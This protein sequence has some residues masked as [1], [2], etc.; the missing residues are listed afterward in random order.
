MCSSWRGQASSPGSFSDVAGLLVAPLLLALVLALM[1]VPRAATVSLAATGL[2]FALAKTTETG[3]ETATRWSAVGWP[4]LMLRDAT[5]LVALPILAVAAWSARWAQR[6]GSG[7]RRVWLAAGSLALP[8]A[9]VATAATS[10]CHP[11]DGIATV[12]VVRGDFTGPP[13]GEEDRIVLSVHSALHSID[14][15]GLLLRV[16]PVDSAA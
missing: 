9:V 11:P 7:H 12:G 8:F 1:R 5:D 14:A 10:P 2:G 15:Q 4:T 3:V 16:H 13:S 6:L